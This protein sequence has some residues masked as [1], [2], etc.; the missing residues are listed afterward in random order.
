M[1]YK[2]SGILL[3]AALLIGC[4]DD[5]EELKP[6][7][8]LGVLQ[9]IAVSATS[10]VVDVRTQELMDTYTRLQNTIDD[11][12]INA[13][14]AGRLANLE[15]LLQD[16]LADQSGENGEEVYLPD[17]SKTIEA[18]KTALRQY[19]DKSDNDS[20]YYQMAKAYDLS[21]D[22]LGA[23]ASLTT[24]V[25]KYPS[26]EYFVESQFRRG[27]Y[28]FVTD[29]FVQAEQ[30]FAVVI[31]QG[32]TS[33]FYENALYMHGWSLFKLSQYEDSALDFTKV[34]DRTMPD[35]GELDGVS[36]AQRTLVDDSLRVLG[37]VFSYLDGAQT[38]TELI[39][40]IG[41]RAYSS[42]LYEQ[43]ADLYASQERYRD[44]I[45][46]F[47]AYIQLNPYNEKTAYMHVRMIDTM[48]Q[49]QFYQEAFAE[50]AVFI[51]QYSKDSQ[52]YDQA[53]FEM[54]DY[55]DSYLYV[56]IDEVARFYHARAQQEKRNLQRFRVA[57]PARQRKM[58]DDYREAIKYYELFVTS[59]VNDWHV[60]EKNY[61][62]AEAYAEL[63]DYN[64]A[65]EFYERT[66]YDYG[67]NSFS[68]DAAYASILA[69][70][71]LLKLTKTEEDKKAIIARKLAAQIAFA[72]AY[73]F[74]Q[75]SRAVM[76]D[77]I[78]MMYALQDYKRAAEQGQ[79]FLDLKP[80]PAKSERLSVLLVMAHSQYETQQYAAA[81][82]SYYN[83]LEYLPE[84]DKRRVQ[85]YDRIAASVYKQAEALAAEGK[86]L[87]AVDQLLRV[88]EI[89]PRS[90]YRKNAEYDAATYL[91][92]AEAWPR[93]LEVTQQYRKRYD[94]KRKDLDVTGKMIAIYEGMGQLDKAADELQYV[95][96]N[97]KD[98]ETQR[99]ALF[100]SAEYYEK[101]GDNDRALNAFR[102]YANRYPEPFDLAIETQYRLSEM[103]KKLNDDY[104]RRFWLDKVIVKDKKAGSKRTDRSKYLA[105]FA[106]NVFAKDY[107][108]AFNKIKLKLPLRNSI[109][110]KKEAMELALKKYR[111]VMDYQVQEFTTQ[112]T[113]YTGMIYS[114]FAKDLMESERPRGFSALELEQYDLLLEEQVYPFEDSAIEIHE[115]NVQNS[116]N[117]NYDRWV[118]KSMQE[119]ARL[120][121]GQYNK[122]EKLAD[123]SDV[124]F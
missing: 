108:D 83:T 35:N 113:Y 63:G 79:R 94:P 74:S 19:P 98:P 71:R 114:Q 69:Y 51:N 78:D 81:E 121:P 118:G 37:I 54:H 24:L 52:Y 4:G 8:S 65:I 76:L 18:Y 6:K 25:N 28:L 119:L 29:R 2:L 103:Y 88:G 67:I 33:S 122:Q 123:Y 50:K 90:K 22:S 124:I 101:A 115:A 93:A 11:E 107:L 73:A 53:E 43:L 89:S 42:L 70:K 32:K 26:S 120:L 30:A 31:E 84:G 56:Y 87:E 39:A 38:I 59:F 1:S 106:R 48:L 5:K 49:A 105:A 17:Y 13:E 97:A 64:K 61:M 15:L 111:Q 91:I 86:K 14:I 55:L 72:E 60:P 95:V 117:G 68:E 36:P 21:G 62:I 41:P 85:I 12:D 3:V 58:L 100:L 20:L 102:S 82:K 10:D 45:Q 7:N 112:S 23:L 9:P 47:K 27:D 57:P 99:K 16:Q 34:L 66:A 109:G 110:R 46:T 80:A 104:R 40:K 75:Y 44:A 92:Q 77:S 116:W 96:R